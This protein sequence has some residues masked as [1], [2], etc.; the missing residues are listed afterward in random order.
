MRAARNRPPR[1]PGLDA[2]DTLGLGEVRAMD[3][4]EEMTP[5]I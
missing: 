2:F 5:T 4:F 3:D 1:A